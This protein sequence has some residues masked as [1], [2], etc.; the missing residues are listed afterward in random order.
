VAQ[1][2]LNEL[3][4]ECRTLTMENKSLQQELALLKGQWSAPSTTPPPLT[5]IAAD[6][7]YVKILAKRYTALYE[8]FSTIYVTQSPT[9]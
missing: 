9:P 4:E 8:P 1:N 5:G 6:I 3:C 7:E 2:E